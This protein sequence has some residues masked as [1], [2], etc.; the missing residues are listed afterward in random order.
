MKIIFKLDIFYFSILFLDMLFLSYN[1]Q[2]V[3]YLHIIIQYFYTFHMKF[4][5]VIRFFIYSC[6]KIL[7]VKK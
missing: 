5:K 4:F 2:G 1:I 3:Q 6:S 7:Y